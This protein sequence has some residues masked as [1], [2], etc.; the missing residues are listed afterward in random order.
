MG[1]GLDRQQYFQKRDEQLNVVWE[2]IPS[3]SEHVEYADE[4][5]HP[6]KNSGDK[7]VQKLEP[8]DGSV[9][10]SSTVVSSAIGAIEFFVTNSGGRTFASIDNE[11]SIIDKNGNKISS[12]TTTDGISD[13]A[14][15]KGVEPP[16]LDT[17]AAQN[18][19]S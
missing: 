15:S 2:F 18:I 5:E 16:T 17:L 14:F 9:I 19:Q 7:K 10:W 8:S 13:V 12:I 11:G 4:Y 1:F 6:F 3:G